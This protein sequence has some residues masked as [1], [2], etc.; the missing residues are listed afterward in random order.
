MQAPHRGV[1]ASSPAIPPDIFHF[2]LRNSHDASHYYTPT[3]ALDEASAQLQLDLRASIQSAL[4]TRRP[5]LHHLNADTSWLLQLPRPATA[6]KKGGRF[7]YNILID[8]W[9]AG[10]QS[11]VASWFSQQF[12]AS[13]SAVKSIAEVEELAREIEILAKGLRLGEGRKGNEEDA[14]G[15][16][17]TFV[18][19]VTVSHPFTDHCHKETLLEV[20]PDVPVFAVEDAVGLIQGWKHF[21]TVITMESFGTNG[22]NDWRISSQPPLPEWISITRLLQK[23]DLLNYH[24]AVMIASNNNTSPTASKPN[25]TTNAPKRTHRKQP[26][27]PSDPAEALI[28]TPHGIS[29][30][31]LYLIPTAHP[32]IHTLAF[33]HGLHNVRIGSTTGR[34]AQQLNTGAHNGLK[35]QRVLGA[36]YWIGTH[37]EVKKG[38]GLVSWFLQREVVS[39]PEALRRERESGGSEGL[40]GLEEGDVEAFEGVNWVELANGESRVLV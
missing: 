31:D 3:M 8:P 18:D 5:L 11:D 27:D 35:A 28:Y 4:S 38:G 23:D 10:G 26:S 33:L 40:V 17:E 15:L 13:E 34:L 20:H 22:N 2:P 19:A 32:P 30:G 6:L 16:G 21:R 37:D 25:S 36:K 9:L 1:T 39:L 14:E 24:S 29:S 7:Y 12:H